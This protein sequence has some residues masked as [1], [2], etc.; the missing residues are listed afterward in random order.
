L[1][2]LIIETDQIGVTHCKYVS[3]SRNKKAAKDWNCRKS[4]AYRG[5]PRIPWPI[6]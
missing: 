5:I 3:C 6:H 1:Y 2:A 4:A